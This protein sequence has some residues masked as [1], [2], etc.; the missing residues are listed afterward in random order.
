M[1]IPKSVIEVA[2]AHKDSLYHPEYR[3]SRLIEA[4]AKDMPE[5]AV[6]AAI[7][8]YETIT[9]ERPDVLGMSAAIAIFLK[10]V[11]KKTGDLPN[12]EDDCGDEN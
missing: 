10:H 1:S 7:D 4:L 11:V 5:S 8:E 9:G 2:L 12:R 6:K 3:A